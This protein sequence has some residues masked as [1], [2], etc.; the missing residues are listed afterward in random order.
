MVNR[1]RLNASRPIVNERGE[2]TAEM[3][4]WVQVVSERALII[5]SGAPDGVVEA[6][7]GAEYMDEDGALGNVFYLKQKEFVESPPGT[8]NRTLGWVLIG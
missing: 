3:Q 8:P 7:Q 6:Q 4:R 1:V 5:G 2:Q